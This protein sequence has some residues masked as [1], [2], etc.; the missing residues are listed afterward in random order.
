MEAN[1]KQKYNS[2]C[3]HTVYT[4][5][6]NY[7]C[8]SDDGNPEHLGR[9][10]HRQHAPEKHHEWEGQGQETTVKDLVQNHQEV[11]HKLRP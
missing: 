6:H 4:A 7:L 10:W 1:I 5:L 8:I 11:T 3:P 2:M 9:A